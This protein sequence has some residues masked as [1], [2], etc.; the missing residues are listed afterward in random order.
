MSHPR[1]LFQRAESPSTR[2]SDRDHQ[3]KP[4]ND[5]IQ[6]HTSGKPSL[7]RRPS[8]VELFYNLLFSEKKN[9]LLE[10]C[11]SAQGRSRRDRS[12]KAAERRKRS[13][14]TGSQPP[15]T[16]RNTNTVAVCRHSRRFA[17]KARLWSKKLMCVCTCSPFIPALRG[18]VRGVKHARQL[19]LACF[20][21]TRRWLG[22]RA[23][24]H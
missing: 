6:K 8:L 18:G 10:K 17:E 1:A 3:M 16:R 19:S 14:S 13:S 9:A 24:S 15:L 21:N 23:R 2:H 4:E 22:S 12:W 7:K 11:W 5:H 20:V